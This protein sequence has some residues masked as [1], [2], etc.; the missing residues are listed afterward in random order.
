L[1]Q[2]TGVGLVELT[3]RDIVRH[4]RVKEIV[5]AYDADAQSDAQSSE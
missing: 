2:I 3:R 4:R 5:R 1:G